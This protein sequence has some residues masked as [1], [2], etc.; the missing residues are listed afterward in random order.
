MESILNLSQTRTSVA[1]SVTFVYALDMDSKEARATSA[2]H[3][4]LAERQ[5]LVTRSH[6]YMYE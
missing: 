6:M 3:Q 1:V 5:T 4:I 2:E